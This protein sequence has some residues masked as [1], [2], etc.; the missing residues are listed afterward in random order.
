MPLQT[1]ALPLRRFLN[2]KGMKRIAIFASGT[3]SNAGKIMER[4]AGNAGV[5]VALVLSNKEG[6]G[7]L[8]LADQFGV[9]SVVIPRKEFVVP[10]KVVEQLAPYHLDLIVL[11][12]FLLKI[13]DDLI[14]AYEQ[15]IINIHPSLL[16][17]YGGKGMYGM[18]VHNAVIAAG[19]PESGITIHYVNEVYDDGEIIFQAKCQLLPEDT[20]EQLRKKIQV[21]EHTHFPQVVENVLQKA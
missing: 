11:A 2:P 16:P 18:N 12:G 15:R 6:A 1:L 21:L 14:Q 5:E 4:F 13:P 19:E 10:G 7:V 17:R 20:P 8:A 3:G 9:P